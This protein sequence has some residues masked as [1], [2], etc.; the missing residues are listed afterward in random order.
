MR[1]DI[2]IPKTN[3]AKRRK[4]NRSN[5]KDKPNAQNYTMANASVVEESGPALTDL[6]SSKREDQP[7]S[8][9]R[10]LRTEDCTCKPRIARTMSHAVYHCFTEEWSPRE[11]EGIDSASSLREPYFLNGKLYPRVETLTII[12]MLLRIWR[13]SA[14]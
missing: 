13:P 7:Q 5:L 3:K 14:I 11:I 12:R 6:P 2:P 1:R 10:S 8:Q 4:S 9:T